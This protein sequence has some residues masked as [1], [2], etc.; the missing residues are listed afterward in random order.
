MPSSHGRDYLAIPGPSIIP[1][2][3]LREMHRPSPNIYAGELVEMMGPL[4]RDLCAVARTAGEVAIYIGNGHAAWEAVLANLVAPGERVLI[5]ATGRFG[6]GW[7]EMARELG[8]DVEILD[9]GRQSPVDLN[10]L[11]AVLR[12]DDAHRIKALL[13]THV[14]TSTGVLN[15]IAGM[16]AA[17]DAVGHPALLLSDNIASLACDRFEMDGW[18]VDA[19]VAGCQKGLMVPPGIS[20]VFVGQR[21]IAKRKNMPRV[22]RYWDFLPRIAPEYF[23]QYFCGTAPTHHLYGLRAALDMIHEEGLEAIWARHERQARA[24]WAACET[25]AEAGALRLNIADPA[26]RSRCITALALPAPQ[27]LDLR[28]WLEQEAG[29]TLGIGLGM[30]TQA[31]PQATG[32][33]RIG[34]MGHVNLHGLMGVFGAIEAGFQALGIAHGQGAI[35]R[36]AEAFQHRDELPSGGG[37]ITRAVA[38]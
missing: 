18:G 14:D 17:L 11:E 32:A 36:A 29:V 30:E 7:G 34:H 31:D 19:M 26:H 20:F 38:E 25:W 22:S 3:V 28:Q 5:P 23:Y 27:G 15:D 21:A 2:R 4:T 33:F 8:I 37:D 1:D 12:A 24:V 10:Q 13:G 35:A 6:H 9:F 16:R